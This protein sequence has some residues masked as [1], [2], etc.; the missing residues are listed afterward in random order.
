MRVELTG[1]ALMGDKEAKLRKSRP[2]P[3]AP[4]IRVQA[5]ALMGDVKVRTKD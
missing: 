2:L 1:V 3:G 4:L 5:Y